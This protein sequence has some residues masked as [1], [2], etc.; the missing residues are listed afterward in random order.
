MS[1]YKVYAHINK[2]NNKIYIGQTSQK[3][4]NN[5][6]GIDGNQY[7]KCPV[8]WNA[9]TKYGFE[10]F[11]HILLFDNL[12]KDMADIIEKE[13]IKKYNTIDRRFGYNLNNG[14]QNDFTYRRYPVYQYNKSGMLIK[15]W[16]SMEDVR[17]ELG[18]KVSSISR[19]CRNECKTYKNFV[20]S[21][22]EMQKHELK[23]RF[24]KKSCRKVCVYTKIGKY[25]NTYNSIKEASE[26]TGISYGS[27][28]TS[29]QHHGSIITKKKYRFIYYGDKININSLNIKKKIEQYNLKGEF[30]KTWNDITE[31]IG[32]NKNNVRECCKGNVKTAGGFIWKYG[33]NKDIGIE[34]LEDYL[35]IYKQSK[36]KK[37][38]QYTI[39][40]DYIT[41]WDC[42]SAAAKQLGHKSG[43]SI[44]RCCNG[45][46]KSCYGFKWKYKNNV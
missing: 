8:F 9:I 28:Q 22:K 31:I 25:L 13:L 12:S 17:D 33:D 20:W 30:I 38:I 34:N 37:V 29:C 4:L 1:S 41:T 32:F 7:R 15:K 18:Y 43:N 3:N 40:G 42:A 36:I 16:D 39:D 35:K 5:R 11:Q 6:F 23:N 27:I 10:N 19:C 21:Y 45:E 46:I 2:I 44:R 26:D 24:S 14:G